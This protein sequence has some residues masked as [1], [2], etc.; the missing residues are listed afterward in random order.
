VLASSGGIGNLIAAPL[1]CRRRAATDPSSD[2][3]LR[4]NAANFAADAKLDGN[5]LLR[6]NDPRLSGEDI[7]RGYKQLLEV[8]RGWRHMKQV[9]DLRPVF[10]R[11]EDGIRALRAAVLAR[12]APVSNRGDA[13]HQ[14]RRQHVDQLAPRP[15]E[16]AAAARRAVHG[17]AGTFCQTTTPTDEP[18]RLHT[19]LGPAAPPR[20]LH[21]D[22]E[23]AATR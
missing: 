3:L 5:Y 4:L 22:T 21:L 2:G 11:L 23:P 18:R 6:T 15:G 13:H 8:E 10:H 7:A 17:P 14:P 1:Q 12:P 19:A 16:P 9:L 20:I